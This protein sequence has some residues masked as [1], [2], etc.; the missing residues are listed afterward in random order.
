MEHRRCPRFSANFIVTLLDD[1]SMPQSFRIRD[2]GQWGMLLQSQSGSGPIWNPGSPVTLRLSLRQD[3]G[4][5]VLLIA[6]SVQR[7]EDKGLAIT[8]HKQEVHLL[9]QLQPYLMDVDQPMF[10]QQA[11]G[12]AAAQTPLE[13]LDQSQRL[14]F[15]RHRKIAAD[16]QE[17]PDAADEQSAAPT[18]R[19]LPAVTRRLLIGSTSPWLSISALTVSLAAL[20]IAALPR[21]DSQF[22]DRIEAVAQQ[23]TQS[24]DQLNDRLD[25]ISISM[26]ALEIETRAQQRPASV[27]FAASTSGPLPVHATLPDDSGHPATDTP[28]SPEAAPAAAADRAGSGLWIINLV[29]LN[30]ADASQRFAERAS[31]LGISVEP[32]QVRVND[33]DV[34]R[35]QLSGFD[36]HAEALAYS[37]SHKSKLGIKDVWI[38]KGNAGN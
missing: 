30:D 20:L 11:A 37:D 6:A 15:R 31:K 24:L 17:F 32:K 25:Q 34:W 19:S 36:S 27:S 5:D 3:D 12:A 21:D 23:N 14:E 8:F 2:V 16:R 26:A 7:V 1:T 28:P 18:Q 22:A 33:R 29:S 9:K 10:L 38:F 4:R 13:R 35:M